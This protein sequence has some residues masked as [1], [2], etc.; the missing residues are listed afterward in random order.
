MI[1]RRRGACDALEL[2]R[3]ARLPVADER[4]SGGVV[5]EAIR[6]VRELG[7]RVCAQQHLVVVAVAVAVAAD[8]Q[9]VAGHAHDEKLQ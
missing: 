6:N 5:A 8:Q 7:G 3:P 9:G 2:R 1:C 4:A